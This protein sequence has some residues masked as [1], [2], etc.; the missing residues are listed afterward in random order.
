MENKVCKQCLEEKPLTSVYWHKNPWTKD[1]YCWKCKICR[2]KNNVEYRKTHKHKIKMRVDA[3]KEHIQ[4]YQKEYR[5]IT[6]HANSYYLDIPKVRYVLITNTTDLGVSL[7]I[8]L[9]PF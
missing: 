9:L 6:K 7:S 8:I 3:H 5:V 4:K 1:W 2:S